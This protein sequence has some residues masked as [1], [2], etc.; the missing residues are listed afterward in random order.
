MSNFD[1][2]KM[3][4]LVLTLA[5]IMGFFVAIPKDNAGLV[6]N[7]ISALIGAFTGYAAAKA[8]M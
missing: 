7:I 8:G 2:N 1:L 6:N 4:L 3:I 5:L